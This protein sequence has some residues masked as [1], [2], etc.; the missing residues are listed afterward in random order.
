[1]HVIICIYILAICK[2]LINT[3]KLFILFIVKANY[4]KSFVA[5]ESPVPPELVY[6]LK[7]Y[8]NPKRFIFIRNSHK[9]TN[10]ETTVLKINLQGISTDNV[11]K[12][13]WFTWIRASNNFS[14]L[15]AC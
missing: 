8:Y 15:R 13:V 1:M 12:N 4:E 5:I 6:K 9:N 10:V 7:K 3:I 11:S 2:N 14:V